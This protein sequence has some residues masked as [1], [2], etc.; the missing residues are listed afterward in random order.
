[1]RQR[2]A[3]AC[4]VLLLVL[5][6]CCAAVRGDTGEDKAQVLPTPGKEVA[7]FEVARGQNEQGKLQQL[8]TDYC[9]DKCKDV[10]SEELFVCRTAVARYL[11]YAYHQQPGWHC[12]PAETLSREG[13]FHCV[14]DCGERFLCGDAPGPYSVLSWGDGKEMEKIIRINRFRW[15]QF[16]TCNTQVQ[17]LLDAYCKETLRFACDPN[18][19]SC[20]GGAVARREVG[21]D[22]A[23]G[24]AWRC[25][26][27]SA[28]TKSVNTAE[29]LQ[30]CNPNPVLC[31][32]GVQGGVSSRH[33]DVGDALPKIIAQATVD[34]S[35]EG[36][37]S[38]LQEM[39]DEACR[40][41]LGALCNPYTDACPGGAMARKEVKSEDD[42]D[43]QWR[44]YNPLAL[45][46]DIYSALC[47][48]DCGV[49]VPCGD[50]V[51]LTVPNS[52]FDQLDVQNRLER[53]Q[54]KTCVTKPGADTPAAISYL[55]K[56]LDDYC[57]QL[58]SDVCQ[59]DYCPT[60]AVA[61]K[62]VGDSTQQEKEWRCYNPTQL[63]TTSQTAICITDCGVETACGDGVNPGGS[64]SHWTRSEEIESLIQKYKNK[65]CVT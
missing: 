61:R 30:G 5:C 29:C 53:Y 12:Y 60:G 36:V 1:M 18:S 11:P 55:Q 9:V 52:I 44:C 43:P 57:K 31:G 25:Y 62:D 2:N 3:A 21:S 27:P 47:V 38:K 17:P 50:G 7:F 34:Y 35:A 14:N 40:I 46:K 33:W 28:L 54:E 13:A 10:E 45:S 64:Y 58:L 63:T 39:L 65:V 37:T 32:D 49:E 15:C 24:K 16:N 8:L 26:A 42:T 41:S 51:D 4:L 56:K 20:S 22:A 23:A 6:C 19:P 48:T 59:G